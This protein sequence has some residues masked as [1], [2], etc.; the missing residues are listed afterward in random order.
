MNHP[1]STKTPASARRQPNEPA[2]DQRNLAKSSLTNLKFFLPQKRD[3]DTHSS[4]ISTFL[5][6][7]FPKKPEHAIFWHSV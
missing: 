5:K 3:F 1:Q 7:I 6:N 4:L 2:P